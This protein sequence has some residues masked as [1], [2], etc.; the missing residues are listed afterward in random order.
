[1]AH[2]R[3]RSGAPSA[4]ETTAAKKAGGWTVPKTAWG[5]PDLQGVWTSDDMRSVPTQRA[6]AFGERESLTPEE[7]TRRATGDT[8]SRDRAIVLRTSYLVRS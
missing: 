6:E 5:H 3:D 1:M 7:F 2:P 4:A 8:G